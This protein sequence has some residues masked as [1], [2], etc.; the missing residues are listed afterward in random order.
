MQHRLVRS[1][2]RRFAYPIGT[3]PSAGTSS[4]TVV[5]GRARVQ[6][7]RIPE[8]SKY[9]PQKGGMRY[10]SGFCKQASACRR[11]FFGAA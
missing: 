4:A 8:I 9:L 6:A 10:R 1:R 5:L 11:R 2:V 7:R 3:P